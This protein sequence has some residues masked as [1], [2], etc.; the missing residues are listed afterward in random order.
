MRNVHSPSKAPIYFIMVK[1]HFITSPRPENEERVKHTVFA[2]DK[3]TLPKRRCRFWPQCTSDACP[4][5]HPTTPCKSAHSMSPS[6]HTHSL[7]SELHHYFN[8]TIPSLLFP[9]YTGTFQIVLS[10]TNASLSTRRAS[11]QATAETCAASTNTPPHP[12][13]HPRL[14]QKV[15]L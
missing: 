11:S 8:S 13:K 7:S 5:H 15:C 10:L 4:F 3:K 2:V 1:K 12:P 6:S 14:L 9:H